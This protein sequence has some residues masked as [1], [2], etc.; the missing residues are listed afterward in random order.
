MTLE[1]AKEEAYVTSGIFLVNEFPANILFDFGV[2]YSFISHKFGRRQALPA[3]KLDN[4]LI[5]EVAS[6]KFVPVSEYMKNIII[7]LN[8]N[9]FHE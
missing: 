5:V 6:G 2:N 4:A 8:G 1:A 3:D 7:D 9:K